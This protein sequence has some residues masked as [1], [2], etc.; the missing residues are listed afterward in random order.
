M[1]IDNMEEEIVRMAVT[2]GVGCL[3]RYRPS[4]RLPELSQQAS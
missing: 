4:Y 2:S 3:L 1:K